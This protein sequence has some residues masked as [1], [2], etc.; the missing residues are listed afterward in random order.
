M[1][2]LAIDRSPWWLHCTLQYVSTLYYYTK[3]KHCKGAS[4]YLIEKRERDMKRVS[5]GTTYLYTLFAGHEKTS[6][7]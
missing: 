7:V 2:R 4:I 6:N 3:G 1:T 5:I